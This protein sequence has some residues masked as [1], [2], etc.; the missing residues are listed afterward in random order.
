VTNQGIRWTSNFATNNISTANSGLLGTFGLFS[1]P[2]GDPNAETS[3]AVCDVPDP[4]P[5]ECFLHDGFVGTSDG[6]GTLYGVGAW[7]NGTS[8]AEVALFLDDV[9]VDF[10][11]IGEDGII[12]DWTFLGATDTEGFNSFEFRELSGKGGQIVAIRADDVTIGAVPVPPAVWLFISGMLGLAGV[13][14][15]SRS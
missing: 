10:G 15:R 6:A 5:E 9:E 11:A 4:I 7:I 14:R 13:A 3:G 8:G 12:N 1:N 2:S